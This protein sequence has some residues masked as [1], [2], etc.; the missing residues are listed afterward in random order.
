MRDPAAVQ[1]VLRRAVEATSARTDQTL[2]PEVSTEASGTTA[3]LV[4]TVQLLRTAPL[5]RIIRAAEP[6]VVAIAEALTGPPVT[7]VTPAWVL[8]PASTLVSAEAAEATLEVPTLA[9]DATVNS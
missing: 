5:P 2:R 7:A 1:A 8:S 4:K 3:G 6:S 9:E